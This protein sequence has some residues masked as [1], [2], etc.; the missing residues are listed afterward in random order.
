MTQ[1]REFLVQ[2]PAL[3]ASAPA[4]A[5]E[6]LRILPDGNPERLRLDFN[7]GRDRVRL[8]FVLSPT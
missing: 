2:I 6:P 1:R 5:Q 3:L 8:L 4:L 7:T